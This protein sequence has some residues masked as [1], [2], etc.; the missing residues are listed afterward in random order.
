MSNNGPKQYELKMQFVAFCSFFHVAS[1]FSTGV[2]NEKV[3]ER[4][5]EHFFFIFQP[6]SNK[7]KYHPKSNKTW[8][9]HPK[10]TS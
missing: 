6:D 3:L 9:D 4:K 1:L 2:D 8:H 10:H 5:T 7:W